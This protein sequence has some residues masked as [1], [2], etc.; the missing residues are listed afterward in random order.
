[1]FREPKT[2]SVLTLEMKTLNFFPIVLRKEVITVFLLGTV[3]SAHA[4]TIWT[5][6]N[7]GFFHPATSN[8]SGVPDPLMP[9]VA[10]NR[11]GSF[12]LFN[13]VSESGASGGTSPAGTA[14]AVGTLSQYTN[15]LISPSSFGACPLE[16]GHRPPNLIGTTYVVHLVTDNIYLQLML[17]NWGDFGDTTFGYI[18]STPAVAAPPPTPTISITNPSANAIFA[19]PAN[20]KV[21]ANAAVSSGTVTN[22]QFFTN[23][24]SYGSTIAAPFNLTTPGLAAGAYALTAAATAGGISATSGV[25][26]ITVV[27]PIPVTLSQTTTSAGKIFQFSYSANVGLNYVIQ[28]NTNLL[29]TNWVSLATNLAASNPTNFVDIHA[30]NSSGFYRVGRL[31]NP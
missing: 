31:S 29:S 5:G 1:M 26:N 4:Q 17:T 30:T 15:G 23:G 24:A 27:N 11:G 25:V 21:M 10:F 7:Y 6:T 19:A 8:P 14:W 2:I 9:D 20:V 12:G 28:V 18:R 13:S 22:V 3:F 16:Q